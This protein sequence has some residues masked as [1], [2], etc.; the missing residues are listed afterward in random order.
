MDNIPFPVKCALLMI[1]LATPMQLMAQDTLILA[2]GRRAAY[3]NIAQYADAIEITDLNSWT[4]TFAP[5]SV[6]GYCSTSYGI[7]YYRKP[8]PS[9]LSKYLMLS[10]A[11]AGEISLYENNRG[12]YELYIEKGDRFEKIMDATFTRE[13]EEQAFEVFK[14]FVEDDEQSLAYISQKKFSFKFDEI[15]LVAEYYNRRNFERQQPDALDLRGRVYLYRT[16]FQKFK[17]GL[18]V[19][20]YGKDHEIFVEDYIQ[21]E[22]P[23]EYP[24][25]LTIHDDFL[26]SEVIVSGDLTD[27]YYEIVYDNKSNSFVIEE[28]TGSE[29]QYEFNNIR[30][31]VAREAGKG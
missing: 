4:E 8:D 5:D 27:R 16:K 13:G 7:T 15:M 24:S 12:V 19:R 18:N 10:R 1:V 21:L 6:V 26:R 31:K 2:N 3:V 14:S 29:L 22:L 20:A 25:R 17:T 9:G 11:L 23:I 30:D 28:K